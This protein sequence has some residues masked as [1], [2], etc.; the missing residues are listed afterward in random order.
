[1][2]YNL[3]I[4][5]YND[6]L[7]R[8]EDLYDNNLESIEEIYEELDEDEREYTEVYNLLDNVNALLKNI[9]DDIHHIKRIRHSLLS[10][11][12]ELL[13][14]VEMNSDDLREIIEEIDDLLI[15]KT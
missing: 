11:R 15:Q 1:M 12:I 14:S 10:H 3:E 7:E 4:K 6:L 13:E 9:T 2:R 8:V 5:K